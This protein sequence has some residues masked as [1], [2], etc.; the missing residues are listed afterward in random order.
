MLAGDDRAKYGA[1][2]AALDEVRKAGITQVS[3]ETRWRSSGH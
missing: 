3:V 1:T 2:V